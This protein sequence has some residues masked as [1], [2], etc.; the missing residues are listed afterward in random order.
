MGLIVNENQGQQFGEEA[1]KIM[2]KDKWE[3]NLKA[4]NDDDQK[5]VK[6]HKQTSRSVLEQRKGHLLWGYGN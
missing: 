1:G 2:E 5:K 3:S 6:G 4:L